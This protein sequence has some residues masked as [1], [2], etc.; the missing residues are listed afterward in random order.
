ME[1]FAG[2]GGE[3]EGPVGDAG[4]AVRGTVGTWIVRRCGAGS[5]PRK[6]DGDAAADGLAGYEERALGEEEH[7][8][9]AGWLPLRE[10][11]ALQIKFGGA[12]GGCDVGAE[13][14][15]LGLG[16]SEDAGNGELVGECLE[17]HLEQCIAFG[18]RVGIEE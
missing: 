8:L 10:V 7:G 12:G 3:G 15:V 11:R 13:E 9:L 5:K 18:R 14:A 6:D 17:I 4:E 2:E 16:E 1:V